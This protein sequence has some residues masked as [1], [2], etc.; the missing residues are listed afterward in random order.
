MRLPT[1][2]GRQQSHILETTGGMGP[3]WTHVQKRQWATLMEIFTGIW[4][5]GQ[6]TEIAPSL[7]DHSDLKVISGTED[8]RTECKC[9]PARSPDRTGVSAQTEGISQETSRRRGRRTRMCA[10]RGATEQAAPALLEARWSVVS[11]WKE[12]K[13]GQS[14]GGG[15]GRVSQAKTKADRS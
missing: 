1:P 15:G 6:G 2:E 3:F 9:A 14:G 7:T 13:R 12:T 8:T 10:T 4:S 11:K 5:P